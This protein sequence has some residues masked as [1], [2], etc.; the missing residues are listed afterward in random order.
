MPVK[1]RRHPVIPPK[2]GREEFSAG[3]QTKCRNQVRTD[4][5]NLSSNLGGLGLHSPPLR[6]RVLSAPAKPTKCHGECPGPIIAHSAQLQGPGLSATATGSLQLGLIKSI[7]LPTEV[8][9][10]ASF[11]ITGSVHRLRL[12][13][14]G[15]F[16]PPSF[17]KRWSVVDGKYS[18]FR[19]LAFENGLIEKPCS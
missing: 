5:G 4:T 18:R 8:M 7:P 14:D 11:Q 6:D 19:S 16:I 2:G 10:E 9:K 13:C 17:K 3:L 12:L 15:L 1:A